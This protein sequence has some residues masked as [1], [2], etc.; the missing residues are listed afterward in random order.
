[1]L[2]RLPVL[3]ALSGL[4]SSSLA[5]RF[6]NDFSSYPGGA[7]ACLTTADSNAN[8]DGETV[9]TMNA[10]LCSD[11]GGFLTNTARCLGQ[12]APGDID[13]T[14]GTLKVNCNGSKTPLSLSKDEF[15]EIADEAAKETPPARR[16]PR[17]DEGLSSGA[18]IGI[19]VGA[20]LGGVAL[21]AGLA[22]CLWRRRKAAKS[23]KEEANPMLGRQS[24]QPSLFD[25]QGS[26]TNSVRTTSM[27]QGGAYTD[28]KQD[29]AQGNYTAAWGPDS[30][31]TGGASSLGPTPPP[32]QQWNEPPAPSWNPR[33]AGARSPRHPLTRIP[34][35]LD[36]P[37]SPHGLS[38]RGGSGRRYRGG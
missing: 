12:N 9:P 26:G 22:F 8:C 19:A 25:G 6:E 30:F 36:R 37:G 11:G 4:I 10:C 1:M 3:V 2:L 32:P 14:Y 27:Y 21:I 35:R 33:P 29:G 17:D 34:A 7:Q 38:T 13:L 15:T 24:L 31:T 28:W 18:T 5:A 23:F 20:A 16:A